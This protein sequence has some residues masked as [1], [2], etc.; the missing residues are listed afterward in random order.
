MPNPFTVSA[1]G[2]QV[3]FSQGNL[4]Y[5]ASTYTWRFAENQNE[6]I[7][8]AAGNNTAEA[9]RAT[10]S[11]W[12][13]LFG[14]GTGNNPTNASI[15]NDDYSTWN[16]WGDNSISNGG[17]LP[18][19]WN[20][21]SLDEWS[22]LFNTRTSL[23]AT[24][25]VD[26]RAGLIIMPD[27]W[28]AS[29][30]TPTITTNDYTTNVISA[31]DWTVLEG[32]GCIFLPVTGYRVG[33]A[34]QGREDIHGIYWTSTA[35]GTAQA[36]DAYIDAA[37]AHKIWTDESHNRSLG[38]G[39][40]L[41]FQYWNGSGTEADPYQITNEYD[42]NKLVYMVRNGNTFSGEYFQLTDDIAITTMVGTDK[43][44]AFNGTFDG[45][46][47]TI[48][49]TLNSSAANCAPFAYT[50]GATIKN[51][52]VTG[53]ITTSEANAGGVVGRNGTARLTLTNISCNMTINSNKSGDASHGGL[54]GYAI[55]ATI[56]GCSFTGKL[57]G[58]NSSRFG[59]LVG[60]KSNTS[61]SSVNFIDCLFAP[62]QVTM[63]ASSSKTFA[64]IGGGTVN[65]TNC[66]YTQAYGTDQGKQARSV[67]GAAGVTVANAGTETVYNV[68]GITSYGT[69]IKYNDVLY[70]GNGDELSLNLSGSTDY[71]PSA[72]TLTG[73]D[74]YTLTMADANTI[75]YPAATCTAPTAKNLTYTG[76][77][78]DLLNAGTA[79]GGT[80]WYS[81]DGT[82]WSN[83]I[84]TGI[85]AGEY[86][87]YYK[88]Q[89]DA[90]H[91]D[92]TPENNKI[93][94][95]IAS[96]AVTDGKLPSKFS[97]GKNKQVKFSQGNLQYQQSTHTWR[98]APVQTD[99]RGMENL[100]MGNSEYDGWVDLF[101]WSLGA[102]N[103]YGATSDYFSTVYHNADF[104]DWGDRISGDWSTMSSEEF[105]YILEGRPNANNKW[106]MAKVDDNYGLVLLPDE[107]TDP[108]GITFVPRTM[109]TSDLW[110][111]ADRI[112]NTSYDHYR[113]RDE[114]MPANLFTA[115]QWYQ[116]EANG[117]IFLPCAGR[118]SGGYGNHINRND[119][120]VAEEYNYTYYENYLGT[121]WTNTQSNP[122]EGKAHYMYTLRA[123][124]PDNY[125]WG[126]PVFWGE[127]GRYG[128]SVRL[129]NAL[130]SAL[131]TAPQANA[132][133]V[134]DGN[135]QALITEGEVVSG[136]TIEYK[137][138]GGEWQ[139]TVP[140]ATA[141]G[142]YTVRYRVTGDNDHSN[143]A[144]VTLQ[145]TIASDAIVLDEN[146]VDVE[147]TLAGL[148]S[149]SEM[150]N[151]TIQRSIIAGCYNTIC[152]PFDLSAEQIAA[153]PLAGYNLL[154]AFDGADVSGSGQNLLLNLYVVNSDHIEAG[155]P[156]LIS[157]PSEH[158]DIVNP[159]F[160]GVTITAAVPGSDAGGGVTFRGMFA[161]VHIEPYTEERNEDYLFLGAN[162]R[163]MWPNNDGTSMRG[164]R[165]YFIVNRTSIPS[166]VAPRGTAARIV[167]RQ[168]TPTDIET[169]TVPNTDVE[170][171]KVL[172][173]G[174]L[175]IIRN[176][177]KYNLSGQ[178]VK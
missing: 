106:G 129:T 177:V 89:G 49:A 110:D 34:L 178:I 10:Q 28:T 68:S 40:R 127:N 165:A 67:T 117:A 145:V 101:C 91:A 118:R 152:L 156:Y 24:A 74:P 150:H 172:M 128:Q 105:K 18:G 7:G 137:L 44:H 19:V 13:D 140:T 2:K 135:A 119:Q 80:M 100:Q 61:G 133:L 94:V 149:G 75:I 46:G 126:R 6:R 1:S 155:K 20:T 78:Q 82:I 125:I 22:Y 153:G 76:I 50:Y 84:P 5:Q 27:G 72:G 151:V 111:D 11:D 157:F 66:Y 158:G 77:A 130:P 62:T 144:E 123:T 132:G 15:N 174:V 143:V 112:D 99:W 147:T 96:A 32:E 142:S 64:V 73:A 56:T 146:D 3:W 55:N 122:E 71:K 107:W 148:V 60:W 87:V 37:E 170:S 25:T 69:G 98:L 23:R 48:T 86:T 163:I 121:Y 104:V 141:A 65:F 39:V 17:A 43:D 26:G 79:T 38:I 53:T 115:A 41:V 70:G 58:E 57:L 92:Y 51:L 95:I 83:S 160:D 139:T 90:T 36:R 42:W 8:N 47:H 169:V 45:A 16:D 52:H 171:R 12:I 109:P 63:N 164:F 30:V 97:V 175:Y 176:G 14:W 159:R 131:I 59:G 31:S 21:L 124:T 168:N 85:N 33:V 103:N 93:S 102:T 173:N 35:S 114:N 54:V 138:D 161:P 29:T 88:V 108:A 4:Q 162:N 166:A 116:L 81:T 134:Y 167:T 120:Y 154:Q 113:V 9:S 136:S